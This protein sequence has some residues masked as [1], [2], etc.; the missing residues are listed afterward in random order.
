MTTAMTYMA[1][2]DWHHGDI[3]TGW[4]IVMM[5]VMVVFWALVIGGIVW[6]LRAAASGRTDGNPVS[7]REILD[8]RLARGEIDVPEYER[9]AS[10]ITNRG[11]AP[12]APAGEA[13]SRWP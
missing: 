9:R 4:W 12:P 2:V 11:E 10:V 1:T 8:E 7:A 3:G 13:V 5:V 6:L